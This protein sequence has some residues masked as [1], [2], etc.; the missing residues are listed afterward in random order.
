M[1]DGNGSHSATLGRTMQEFLRPWKLITLTIGIAIL[2]FGAYYEQ[3]PD[4][5]V[6][7]SILMAA[8]T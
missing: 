2:I 1:D 3:S 7:I 8:L 4:W 6:G 5:D